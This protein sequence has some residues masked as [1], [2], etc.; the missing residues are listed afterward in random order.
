MQL[1]RKRDV[2]APA[3]ALF[4]ETVSEHLFAVRLRKAYNT[5]ISPGCVENKDVVC[6]RHTHQ[7]MLR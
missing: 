4:G 7:R 2:I 6:D 1:R 5:D 3:D